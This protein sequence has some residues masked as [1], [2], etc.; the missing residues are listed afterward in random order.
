MPYF[1]GRPGG[2]GFYLCNLFNFL[3]HIND[4]PVV[5]FSAIHAGMVVDHLLFA[6]GTVNEV[7]N[8]LEPH[9][10]LAF[11]RAVTAFCLALGCFVLW[12]WMFH[13]KLKITN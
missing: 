6:I 13:L 11:E 9:D 2:L 1:K 3:S 7:N 12:Y 5:V 8:P 10:R 4:L